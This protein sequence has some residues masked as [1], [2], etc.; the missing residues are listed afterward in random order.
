MGVAR[1][2]VLAVMAACWALGRAVND[3]AEETTGKL[4]PDGQPSN[5]TGSYKG[6]WNAIFGSSELNKNS[7]FLNGKEGDAILELKIGPSGKTSGNFGVWGVQG[8]VLLRDGTHVTD[9]DVRFKVEGAYV[10]DSGRLHAVLQPAH[11]LSMKFTEEEVRDGG[12]DYREA[13]LRAARRWSMKPTPLVAYGTPIDDQIGLSKACSFMLDLNVSIGKA[14]GGTGKEMGSDEDGTRSKSDKPSLQLQGSI[15][16]KN[17][18]VSLS[19]T[20]A[21]VHMEAYFAK[22]LHYTLATTV[23]TFLQILLLIK[24]I[25]ATSTPSTAMRVSLLTVSHQTT[26]DAYLC[27][28]HLTAGIVLDPLFNTFAMVSFFEFILFAIFEMRYMLLVWRAQRGN[29]LDPFDMRRELSMLYTRFY[30]ALLLGVLL[31]YKLQQFMNVLVFGLYSFWIPQIVHCIRKGIRQPLTPLYVVGTSLTRALLPMYIYGCPK[32]LLHIT[33]SPPM[34]IAI[35]TYMGLQ[36]CTLL[37]QYYYGPTC[38]IPRRFLPDKHDYF[39]ALTSE[40]LQAL[41]TSPRQVAE[42]GGEGLMECV[43]CM[44]ALDVRRPRSRMVAPCGHFFHSQ[45]LQ[46]WMD[47]KMECP[48]CRQPLPPL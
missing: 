25:E 28:L 5:I 21:T 11:L 32:N 35:G 19:V 33:A 6:S 46:R 23:V 14:E 29:S 40:E 34:C 45:C 41:A 18:N 20:A 16:S 4:V 15:S 9:S 42:E 30:G 17:C 13:L 12:P 27:L 10:R 22:A 36:V 31:A 24:Q 44:S 7:K 37:L 38:F 43:I 26:M 2:S 8:D 3:G 47:V 1:L 48:T 39:R